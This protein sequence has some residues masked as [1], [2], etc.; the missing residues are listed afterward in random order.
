MEKVL[1][2]E[3]RLIQGR[4]QLFDLEQQLD[5]S[6]QAL[7]V[8]SGELANAQATLQVKQ[9][10]S[11]RQQQHKDKIV[12]ILEGAIPAALLAVAAQWLFDGLERVIL[13]KGLRLKPEQ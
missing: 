12:V 3:S 11:D 5:D 9:A 8:V 6:Q 7:H 1:A 13:P 4:E 2:L 10:E